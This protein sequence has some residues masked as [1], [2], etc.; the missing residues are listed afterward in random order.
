MSTT[1]TAL[2]S[3]T[4]KEG[5]VD[6]AKGLLELGFR[7]LS[8]GGTAKLLR[9]YKVAVT[10]VSEYTGQPESFDGLVKSIHPKIAGG[11]LYNGHNEVHCKEAQS[12]KIDRIDV[13]ACNLYDFASAVENDAKELERL[14]SKIDIGGPTMLRAA[15]KNHTFCLPIIDPKD[16][17]W[18]LQKMQKN[19]VSNQDRKFL[20]SK[21][22]RTISVYDRLIGKTL[23][24]SAESTNADHNNDDL[25]QHLS[26][27]LERIE[28]LRYGE[29]PHQKGAL[30]TRNKSES[31]WN[32]AELLNGKTLSYNNYLDMFSA[33]EIVSE[34]SS[35]CVS[36]VKHNNPCGVAISS[37]EIFESFGLSD[38]FRRAF[39]GDS[40]SAFGGIIASNRIIDAACA[41]NMREYFFE[42]II[43]PEFST[44]AL[45]IL[46]EKK[47]LRLVKIPSFDK[48]KHKLS[49]QL[50]V[51]SIGAD[52]LIQK[53]SSNSD[54]FQIDDI[55]QNSEDHSLLLK[56]D[57]DLAW[58]VVK[59]VKSNAIVLVKEGRCIGVGAGQMSRID[60]VD[61]ALKKA[62]DAG[63]QTK[64][65]VLASDAFFPFRDSI[66]TAA[67]AGIKAII[68]PG[69]SVRDSEV[70]EA[71]NE[72]GIK[73]ILTNTRHFKH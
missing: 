26:I 25:D 53:P 48:L 34:V 10:D 32:S 73:M 51:K 68:Q 36:I 12:S 40:Q 58:H 6:F 37:Q 55:W 42:C 56:Q 14:L 19:Q 39:E 65:A 1:S 15:A 17:A 46:Q 18:V 41:Q 67:K 23:A 2:L 71:A 21:V 64:G 61:L 52:Y 60:A 45:N 31:I 43:A 70:I 22:F 59:N 50:L 3:V 72:H 49:K 28:T 8:T 62:R 7:I 57:L 66:D 27:E 30:Y 38:T 20:A 5:I 24:S 13:V 29:N 4:N 9:Q 63:H 69:G 16:Y 35:P 54:D 47:N 33:L 11:I 44:E